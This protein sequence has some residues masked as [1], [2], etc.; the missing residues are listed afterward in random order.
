MPQTITAM[1][2]VEAVVEISTDG[3]TWSNISGSTTRVTITPQTADSGMAATLEGQFKIVRAGKY[4]SAF[5]PFVKD[6]PSE[7]TL[8]EYKAIL[9]EEAEASVRPEP[10]VISI[11]PMYQKEHPTQVRI[12]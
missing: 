8:E 1:N 5:E 6:E 4:K 10:G 11:L 7:P 12:L 3:A 9:K 2:T